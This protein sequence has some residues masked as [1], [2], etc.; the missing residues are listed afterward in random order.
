MEIWTIG[1][2]THSLEQ[3]VALLRDAGIEALADV[4]TLPKS[5][6]NPHFARE[7][8]ERELP[9]RG[10]RYRHIK[11]LGGWRKVQP[12]SPN[13]GWE[14]GAFQGYADHTATAEFRAG[15]DELEELARRAPTAVMCAEA[16][17][18]RCHRRLIADQLRV[19]G[20]RVLHIAPN[21]EQTEHELTPF[22]VVDGELI[23]YPPRQGRLIDP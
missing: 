21:G 2:S 6:R 1:H 22:A 19:R 4:R 14:E 9:A 18:W 15:L 5:R 3:F 17:W 7:S 11:R 10:F 12:G 13:G 16:L 20:W 23:T 8:L